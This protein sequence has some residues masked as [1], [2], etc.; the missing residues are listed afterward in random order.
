MRAGI[1][2]SPLSRRE[3]SFRKLALH[4]ADGAPY[5]VGFATT[6]VEDELAREPGARVVIDPL[7]EL[8]EC[9]RFVVWQFKGNEDSFGNS[10]SGP[11]DCI[12][13]AVVRPVRMLQ[14]PCGPLCGA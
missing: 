14:H 10:H 6:G 5:R 11:P 9:R 8:S 7:D 1:G 4:H 2:A 3:A 13:V 12:R